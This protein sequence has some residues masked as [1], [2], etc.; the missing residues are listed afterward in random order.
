MPIP[1]YTV[2]DDSE[3]DPGSPGTSSLFTR[4]RDNVLAI[5]GGA[6]AAPLVD[7][8]AI[9]AGSTG[10]DG[11]WVNATVVTG[12]G[13]F[14]PEDIVISTTLALPGVV[15]ARVN[16]DVTISGIV[17]VAAVNDT[18][19]AQAAAHL[20]ATSGNRGGEG[21]G[22]GLGG[23]GGGG[24]GWIGAGGLGGAGG[25]TGGDGGAAIVASVCRWPWLALNPKLGGNGGNGNAGAGGGAGG[26]CL[27]LLVEGDV[28]MTGGAITADAT[29]GTNGG[30]QGGGGGGAGGTIIIMAT[31]TITG[32]TYTA[33]GGSGGTSSSGVGGK[34]GGGLVTLIASAF[35]GS[36]V[37]LTA[38]QIRGLMFRSY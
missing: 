7:R 16:G 9:A 38:E 6:T 21:T 26:G 20:R 37:T 17:T 13:F 33:R 31:G 8:K 24:G 29:A 36:E 23:P 11:H 14:E 18:Q 5:I 4:L 3:I 28:D 34:G 12:M 22:G 2:I 19:I 27:V 35:A 15:I 1:G 30:T 10:T 25:G 32:G